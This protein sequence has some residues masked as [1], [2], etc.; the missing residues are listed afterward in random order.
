MGRNKKKKR[1]GEVKVVCFYCDRPFK[2]EDTLI[3]HQRAKHFKCEV[4][5]RKLSTSKGL[6]T[7][8]YQVHRVELKG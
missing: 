1:E 3:E 6:A 7:H 8:C 5:N 4:C 2:D